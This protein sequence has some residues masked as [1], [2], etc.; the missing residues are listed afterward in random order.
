[1]P[2]LKLVN[3]EKFLNSILEV[4]DNIRFVM[5]YDLNGNS[6]VKRAVDG[7]TDLLTEEE[8]K[9]ALK[10]T[11]DSW[12]FR[13]SVS[14]KI[15]N[16]R[17][18]LQVY[19][20]LIRAIFPFGNEMLLI[21]TLDNS[22]SSSEII[23]RIRKILSGNPQASVFNNDLIVS[24]KHSFDFWSSV[25]EDSMI[26]CVLVWKKILKDHPELM[27]NLP[28]IAN[29]ERMNSKIQVEKF[30][31]SWG[32]GIQEKDFEAAKVVMQEWK[33]VWENVTNDD[34]QLY[35]KILDTLE[36][37]WENTQSKNIE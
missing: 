15:G 23:Q 2:E 36:K 27:K 17:Y 6:I 11:I 19:D 12:N 35:I 18:S 32:R 34:V 21:V 31:E 30:L 16:P 13:N 7:V 24:L 26:N 3:P 8:N 22:G 29:D 4:S 37:S 9:I 20:N 1:M 14:E 5:I 10:H 33:E 25:D 28:L